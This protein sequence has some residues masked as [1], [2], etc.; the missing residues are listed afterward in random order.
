MVAARIKTGA[1]AINDL[2]KLNTEA[3][4]LAQNIQDVQPGNFGAELVRSQPY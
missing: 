1:E 3:Q 2:E 4:V